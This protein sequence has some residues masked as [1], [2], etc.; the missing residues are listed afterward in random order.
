MGTKLPT[1]I[2]EIYQLH[3]FALTKIKIKTKESCKHFISN[4]TSIA[5]IY[6]TNTKV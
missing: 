5:I 3:R 4:V 6:P 2:L 1:T